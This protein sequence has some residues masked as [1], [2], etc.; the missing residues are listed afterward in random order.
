[1]AEA[2]DSGNM[3]EILIR[4]RYPLVYGVAFDEGRRGESSRPYTPERVGTYKRDGDGEKYYRPFFAELNDGKLIDTD[5][6]KKT[7]FYLLKCY[8][9]KRP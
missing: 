4:A 5:D 3:I 9:E 8:F 2:R 7:F 6:N 1:M